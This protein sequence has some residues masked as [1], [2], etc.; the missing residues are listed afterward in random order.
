M[1]R[2][3]FLSA[4]GA[5]AAGVR[6]AGAEARRK[7][8]GVAL[9]TT[10]A[11]IDSRK[12]HAGRYLEAFERGMRDRGWLPGRNVDILVRG[13]VD[14]EETAPAI[15]ALRSEGIDV[16]VV[17]GNRPAQYALRA[18][19]DIPVVAFLHFGVQAGVIDSLARPGRNVTGIAIEESGVATKRLSLLREVAGIKRVGRLHY[20]GP[21]RVGALSELIPEYAE[22]ATRLGIE[23][24]PV[25]GGT[26]ET[27]MRCVEEVTRSG[28]VRG[29]ISTALGGPGPIWDRF[30]EAVAR[31]RVPVIYDRAS[32]VEGG[33]LM[34]YG[35]DWELRFVRIAVTVDRILRGAR[36]ADIP[37]EQPSAFEMVV[38]LD[39]ARTIGLTLPPSVM[40]Q[41]NRVIGSRS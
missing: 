30:L 2:R 4:A 37:V 20:H 31:H 19:A 3:V 35:D 21:F 28:S 10:Q 34:S 15:D 14:G 41:A 33:G 11:S 26:P 38:N 39:A 29:G 32:S 36:P 18:A 40:L 8:V 12:G 16:L 27:V 13:S 1:K 17:W 22:A 24:F 7:R 5:L 9:P 6:I 25:Y 23:V